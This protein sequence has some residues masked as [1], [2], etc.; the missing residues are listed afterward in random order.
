[1]TCKVQKLDQSSANCSKISIP[2]SLSF[3]GLIHTQETASGICP[4][5]L[6]YPVQ[7][8]SNSFVPLYVNQFVSPFPA[9]FRSYFNSLFLGASWKLP[10]VIT[11]STNSE[12]QAKLQNLSLVSINLLI[13]I[14][15]FLLIIRTISFLSH[16][17][18]FL[19]PF[20]NC[21]VC[22]FFF[23]TVQIR[24]E[25]VDRENWKV[26]NFSEI[27]FLKSFLKIYCRDK[28]ILKFN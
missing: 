27:L 17:L 20:T 18:S 16:I 11:L 19:K 26:S 24:R 3:T 13:Y 14:T 1:M 28:R 25:M 10:V 6:S 4:N 23:A 21:S 2:S 9:F 5:Q 7:A 15:K 12:S 8:L 22:I